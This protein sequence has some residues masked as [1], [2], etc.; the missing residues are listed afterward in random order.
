MRPPAQQFP[1]HATV[2]HPRCQCR[3]VC[4]CRRI[5][6]WHHTLPMLECSI[7]ITSRS[8]CSM[9]ARR[10]AIKSRAAALEAAEAQ[11]HSSFSCMSRCH[12]LDCHF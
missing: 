4:G 5:W 1:V 3:N 11:R 6:Q 9:A 8:P 12:L 7:S 10:Q 2:R